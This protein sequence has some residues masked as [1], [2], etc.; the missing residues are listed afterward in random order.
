MIAEEPDEKGGTSSASAKLAAAAF[1]V[2]QL[3]DKAEEV[4]DT[5]KECA[6]DIGEPG[7]DYEFAWG[8]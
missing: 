1:Y 3:Y 6:E 2:F 5:L 4:V 8:W 7:V